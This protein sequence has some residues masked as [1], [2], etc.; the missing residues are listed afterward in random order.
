MVV[1]IGNDFCSGALVR[2][3]LSTTTCRVS[4]TTSFITTSFARLPLLFVVIAKW[5]NKFICNF[6]NF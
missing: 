5:Y 2:L 3:G 1:I 4:A 6:L